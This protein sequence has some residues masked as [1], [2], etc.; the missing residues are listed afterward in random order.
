[1]KPHGLRSF[2]GALEFS[3]FS[4]SWTHSLQVLPCLLQSLLACETSAFW[5]SALN[6]ITHPN[7][8][9]V[10]GAALALRRGLSV[11]LLKKCWR[12]QVGYKKLCS[13][14][15]RKILQSLFLQAGVT[16]KLSNC[17]NLPYSSL[18][19]IRGRLTSAVQAQL[20]GTLMTTIEL[21]TGH[22][23]ASFC[24]VIIKPIFL[25]RAWYLAEN[26]LNP[27]WWMNEWASECTGDASTNLA[28]VF[29]VQW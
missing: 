8:L 16:H 4:W 10:R 17:P 12:F 24:K 2:L 28:S 7:I 13:H 15:G 14:T 11:L 25:L 29:Q 27:F 22:S 9:Q 21:L 18:W 3:S 26:K 23:T 6:L 5:L 1:M 19:Q 20:N